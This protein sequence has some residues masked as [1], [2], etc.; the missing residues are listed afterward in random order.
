MPCSRL[1]LLQVRLDQSW[2]TGKL[3]AQ[4]LLGGGD[5]TSVGVHGSDQVGV[6]A[7]PPALVAALRASAPAVSRGQPSPYGR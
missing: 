3:H 7:S 4:L 6:D 5:A 1:D 2:A